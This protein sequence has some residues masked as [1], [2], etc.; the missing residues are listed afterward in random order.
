MSFLFHLQQRYNILFP[1]HQYSL[2]SGSP[3]HL[4]YLVL[5]SQQDQSSARS[6]GSTTICHKQAGRTKGILLEC[7]C[8]SVMVCKATSAVSNEREAKGLLQ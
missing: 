4:L 7:M 2:H 6:C 1:R 5:S 3:V 8:V